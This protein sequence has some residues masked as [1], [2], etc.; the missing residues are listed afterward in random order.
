MPLLSWLNPPNRSSDSDA[1][2]TLPFTKFQPSWG[3]NL[4]LDEKHTHASDYSSNG[5]IIFFIIGGMAIAEINLVLESRD[6]YQREMWI[7][8]DFSNIRL[9]WFGV[10]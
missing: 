9:G 8:I 1:D 5:R 2:D 10:W 7:G 4:P 3:L 6:Y